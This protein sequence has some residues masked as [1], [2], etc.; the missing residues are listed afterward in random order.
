MLKNFAFLFS[1]LLF[2]N[3]LFA[4]ELDFE[5]ISNKLNEAANEL[6]EELVSLGESDLD[7]AVI[8]GV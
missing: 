2:N 4:E 6:K 7:E 5:E 8:I 1:L 3:F